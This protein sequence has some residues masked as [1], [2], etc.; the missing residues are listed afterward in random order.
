MTRPRKENPKVR[1]QISLEPYQI[2]GVENTIQKLKEFLK[3]YGANDD[4]LKELNRSWLIRE[5]I[6]VIGS[7]AGFNV[8]KGYI[9]LA[10]M[11][12]VG[13]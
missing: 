13:K 2:Q 8:L 4:N 7:E 5:M 9:Q 11:Q 6:D 10:L 3:E 12:K 1:I